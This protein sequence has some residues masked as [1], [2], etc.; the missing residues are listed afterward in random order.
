ML[1]WGKQLWNILIPRMASGQPH[2]DCA[3][4][5]LRKNGMS[6]PSSFGLHVWLKLYRRIPTDNFKLREFTNTERLKKPERVEQGRQR[7]NGP[8]KPPAVL[9]LY[10]SKPSPV[11]STQT[12]SGPPK[13]FDPP[14]A[15]NAFNAKRARGEGT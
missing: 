10:V 2:A 7:V 13:N 1:K 11:T 6:V 15:T 9:P 4:D 14:S 3:L 12:A 5:K 8:P